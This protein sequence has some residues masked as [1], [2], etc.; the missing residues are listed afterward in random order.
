MHARLDREAA[1]DRQYEAQERVSRVVHLS[2]VSEQHLS[3]S[4]PSE[5][6]KAQCRDGRE[7]MTA[8]IVHPSEYDTKYHSITVLTRR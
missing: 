6:N 4:H 8:A 7:N 2:G 3:W 1:D 5:A